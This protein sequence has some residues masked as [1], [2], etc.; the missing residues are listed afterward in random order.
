MELRS[1]PFFESV[2]WEAMLQK[3]V[4]PPLCLELRAG[5]RVE[6]VMSSAAT[7]P[8]SSP[9]AASPDRLAAT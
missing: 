6:A 8:E 2:R 1:L 4:P 9:G 5:W 3:S 7:L